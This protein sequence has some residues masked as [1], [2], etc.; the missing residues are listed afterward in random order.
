MWN[1]DYLFLIRNLVLKDFKVRY[2]NTS[3]GVLWRL[4][5]ISWYRVLSNTSARRDP[6]NLVAGALYEPQRAIRPCGNSL[7]TATESGYGVFGDRYL[8][9]R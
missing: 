2:R 7:G 5:N 1:G 8:R 4:L 3:L 9:L 6:P